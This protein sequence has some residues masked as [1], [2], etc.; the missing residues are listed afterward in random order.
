MSLEVRES[1]LFR[2]DYQFYQNIPTAAFCNSKKRD[3]PG[4]SLNVVGNINND[5]L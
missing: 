4:S 2:T 3:F 5:A 1:P